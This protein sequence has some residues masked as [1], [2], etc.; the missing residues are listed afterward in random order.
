MTTSNHCMKVHLS[1][2]GR[3][4]MHVY[5]HNIE[6]NCVWTQV[7]LHWQ[8]NVEDTVLIVRFLHDEEDH[9][10]TDILRTHHSL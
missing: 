5:E 9:E 4:S 10:G 7:D 6:Q 2:W 3:L 1:V 8:V